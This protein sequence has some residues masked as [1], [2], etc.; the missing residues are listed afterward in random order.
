MQNKFLQKQEKD[1]HYL[2]LVS[3]LAMFV[4]VAFFPIAVGLYIVGNPTVEEN[5]MAENNVDISNL[6]NIALQKPL[7]DISGDIYSIYGRK[8]TSVSNGW[9]FV[10]DGNLNTFWEVNT[11]HKEKSMRTSFILDLEAEQSIGYIQYK[12]DWNEKIQFGESAFINVSV[13][14]KQNSPNWET[15][16][17]NIVSREESE[18]LVLIE[19]EE[20]KTAR[21]IKFEWDTGV[22]WNGKGKIYE[23]EVYP[24]PRLN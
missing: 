7:H 17:E 15:V 19:L 13:A 10:N 4:F 14:N 18:K 9:N 1:K 22:K 21:Y 8:S 12:L 5:T 2:D 23:F 24:P 16:S 6:E 3:V 11:G 20:T